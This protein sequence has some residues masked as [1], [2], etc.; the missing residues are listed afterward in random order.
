MGLKEKGD[1]EDGRQR[2]VLLRYTWEVV[3]QLLWFWDNLWSYLCLDVVGGHFKR[4]KEVLRS[5]MRRS[6]MSGRSRSSSASG[7]ATPSAAATDVPDE[8][9]TSEF[10]QSLSVHA[11][12]RVDRGK[13][14][15]A[16]TVDFATLRAL[17]RTYLYSLT[18]G[19]LLSNVACSNT[20]RSIMDICEVFV[21][22][23][24]RWGGDVL[25]DLLEEGSIVSQD[26]GVGR[27]V[28]ERSKVVH[29][30]HENLG[31][32]LETFQEQLSASLSSHMTLQ[33][34]DVT[35]NTTFFPGPVAT[36]DTKSTENSFAID[37][38]IRRNAERLLLRLNFNEFNKPAETGVGVLR[39]AGLG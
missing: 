9:E 22:S 25:P 7:A 17:H 2:R 37:A 36:R 27:L 20:I 3:R 39:E 29:D 1:P 14:A 31:V 12:K 6:G 18:A 28:L 33:S 11:G 16:S 10:G 38:L 15:A 4:L 30:I 21:A 26:S 24:E 35:S 19:S 5:S 23:V 8:L 32:H 13:R 34:G